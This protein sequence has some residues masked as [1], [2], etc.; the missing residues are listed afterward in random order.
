MFL[1][2]CIKRV[3]GSWGVVSGRFVSSAIESGHGS[4]GLKA[5]SEHAA[6]RSSTSGIGWL[7]TEAQA[8]DILKGWP[9]LSALTR[10]P[11]S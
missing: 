4:Q 9:G 3:R 2:G 5:Y 10:S 7:K 1:L 8:V 6:V 11:L